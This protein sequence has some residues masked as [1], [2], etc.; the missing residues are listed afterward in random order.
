MP[1]RA[2]GN[3]K[4]CL[5]TRSIAV[6]NI[7][8]SLAAA[9]ISPTQQDSF[10][11]RIAACFP[12]KHTTAAILYELTRANQPITVRGVMYRGVSCGLYGST[13]RRNY[14]Q[15]CRILSRL[16]SEGLVP[17]NWIVDNVRNTIQP[18]SWGGLDDF[19]KTVRTAY[20]KDF[21]ASLPHSVHVIIEK[22]AFSGVVA[23]VTQRWGV[24]LHPVRGFISDSFAY[25]IAVRIRKCEKPV[26]C[27]Y[28]G[29]M[30]PSGFGLEWDCR[31]KLEKLSQ[32]KIYWQRLGIDAS[33]IARF[34]LVS[35]PAKSTDTRFKRFKERYGDRAVE[36][37]ALP[38]K[39]A[40]DRVDRAISRHAPA[41]VWARLTEIEKQELDTI[42]SAFVLPSAS[43][44]AILTDDAREELAEVE[45]E[46]EAAYENEFCELGGDLSD[47]DPTAPYF[48]QLGAWGSRLEGEEE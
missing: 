6:Q 23:P 35:I 40:R 31:R 45:A 46:S 25:E 47:Y 15:C 13:D 1:K 2:A 24:P 10:Y 48:G 20:R 26:F 44:T 3:A 29:D 5:V 27:Y 12:K 33:D 22:D 19:A 28:M 43:I 11:D 8:L 38:P 34:G 39:V 42:R 36:L 18:N 17:F 30:D 41:A 32:K 7:K 9:R 21:W 16:R 4:G 37:D 14:D